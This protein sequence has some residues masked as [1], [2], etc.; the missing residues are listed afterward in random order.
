M[1]REARFTDAAACHEDASR[2]RVTTIHP[3]VP[4]P[5][6]ARR[7]FL[8]STSNTCLATVAGLAIKRA[9]LPDIYVPIRASPRDLKRLERRSYVAHGTEH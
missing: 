1:T 9:T 2:T 3:P 4:A 8:I 5:S 7:R 6:S